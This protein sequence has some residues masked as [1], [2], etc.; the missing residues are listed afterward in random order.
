MG[1]TGSG[2]NLAS[3]KKAND[4]VNLLEAINHIASDYILTMNFQDMLNLTDPKYCDKISILTAKLIADNL[5][6]LEVEFLLQKMENNKEINK[7]TKE[8]ILYARKDK[9]SGLDEP[10]AYKKKRMCIGIAEFYVKVAHLFAAI[11]TTVKPNKDYVPKESSSS[12][13]EIKEENAMARARPPPLMNREASNQDDNLMSRLVGGDNPNTPLKEG[14]RPREEEDGRKKPT[15]PLSLCSRRLQFLFPGGDIKNLPAELDSV[16]IDVC[17]MNKP[18][19]TLKKDLGITELE[20]LYK[21]VYDYSE[22]GFTKMSDN[23]QQK[24]QADLNNFYR[25]FTGKNN[26][27]PGITKFSDIP[28][29]DF[30]RDN[31]GNESDQCKTDGNYTK[32]FKKSTTL[33]NERSL[34]VDYANHLKNM[35]QHTTSKQNELLYIIARLFVERIDPKDETKQKI[36]INPAITE[37]ELQKMIEDT[38][39]IIVDLYLT[40]DRD[41]LAGLKLFEKIAEKQ[42]QETSATQL[43]NLESNITTQLNTNTL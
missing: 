14:R 24:Y 41:F 35:L 42:I 13:S 11:V 37:V 6:D 2:S 19:D 17:A 36:I 23:M 22:G 3:T 21:D 43:A 4:P 20:E 26:I 31:E 30:K 27:P 1:N 7:M 39:A 25:Q 16:K 5:K 38:R 32:T 34:F 18:G 12:S 40:C 9:L 8:K 15:D 28:L 10:V 29:M 33:P